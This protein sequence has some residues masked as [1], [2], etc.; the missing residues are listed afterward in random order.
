MAGLVKSRPFR[1]NRI[2]SNISSQ[3]KKKI[4]LVYPNFNIPIQYIWIL[5]I[6]IVFI[7]WIFFIINNTLLRP[8]NYIQNI[9]YGKYS[10][11]MYDNPELYKKI[12][13]LIRWENYFVVSKF[14]KRE[15]LSQLKSEFIMVKNITI[16]QPEKYWASV[17]LEFY[18]PDIVIKLWDKKF[19]VINGE[20]FE[21][22]SGNKI[23]ENSFFVELPQYASGTTS[24]YWLFYEI[25][26][27]KFLDDMTTIAEWFPNYK[28]IVYLPW[29]SMTAVFTEKDQ[30][31]YINNQNSIT[32]QIELFHNLTTF[33]KDASSLNIIDLWSLE[34][35]MV[36]VQ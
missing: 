28:R 6:V 13:D 32:W 11:D 31:V 3:F 23:W 10:V 4:K 22:F 17:Q 7:Y 26:Y 36:I 24:I 8:D 14:K 5:V 9:S 21:I 2:H 25:P 15:I 1:R 12:W 27:Y 35:N 19:W 18:D 20:D 30:R 34:D 33:Y 16:V 29:A